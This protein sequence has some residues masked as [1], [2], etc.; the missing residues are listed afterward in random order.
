MT[1]KTTK[2][3][4][5]AVTTFGWNPTLQKKEGNNSGFNILVRVETQW[6][7]PDLGVALRATLHEV[8][9][10]EHPDR[11]GA[12]DLPAELQGDRMVVVDL[13]PQ[14]GHDTAEARSSAQRSGQ[15]EDHATRHGGS[16]VGGGE[17][18]EGIQID[19]EVIAPRRA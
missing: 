4:T 11:R 8:L 6:E 16:G 14:F 1:K 9:A 19:V 2:K 18:R 15:R 12:A 17:R 3:A 10:V 13:K 5:S 7:R